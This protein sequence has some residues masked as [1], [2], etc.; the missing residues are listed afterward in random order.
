MDKNPAWISVHDFLGEGLSGL[1]ERL[2]KLDEERR[3]VI[4][5]T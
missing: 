4:S 5:R 2:D 1:L 3:E